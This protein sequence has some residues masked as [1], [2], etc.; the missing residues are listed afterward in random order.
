MTKKSWLIV[1]LII[2]LGMWVFYRFYLIDIMLPY[3][4]EFKD[5]VIKSATPIENIDPKNPNYDGFEKIAAAI[6]DSKVV[7]LGEQDHGD[8]PTFLAKT[9]I[10]QYLHEKLGF[11]V[12]VFE[13]NFLGL[14]K[15]LS[16]SKKLDFDTSQD[17]RD[18]IFP[19]WTNC[20]ECSDLFSYIDLSLSTENPFYVSGMDPQLNYNGEEPF[21]IDD[22][23]QKLVEEDIFQ[24]DGERK[25]ITKFLQVLIED[26][27]EAELSREQIDSLYMFLNRARQEL[28]ATEFLYQAV[29]SLKGYALSV[30]DSTESNNARDIQ[31]GDNFLWLKDNVFA[32]KKIIVWASSSHLF[33]GYREL[34]YA[35]TE[36]DSINTGTLIADEIEDELYILGFT[37]NF[38]T[39]GRLYS[40]KYKVFAPNRNTFE[41]FVGETGAEYAFV[42]FKGSNY[43]TDKYFTFFM[44]GLIHKTN[45]F[46]W[47]RM[48]DGV[49][50]IEEMYPCSDVLNIDKFSTE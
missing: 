45:K 21:P 46:N 16:Y 15:S 42:N 14:N 17:Y 7:F 22:I 9:K 40:E 39:A 11:D 37:S 12:L 4:K 29:S 6:G 33:K 3:N 49:F 1:I 36:T 31:M 27:Y 32:D 2:G 41:A 28:E 24:N 13:S 5:F 48:F 43:S 23:I 34:P 18:Y 10:I 25:A 20:V 19:I 26:N 44:K 38:G 35:L 8:A 50:Y 47:T 30:L